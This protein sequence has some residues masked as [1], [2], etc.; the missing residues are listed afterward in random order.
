LDK[1][2]KNFTNILYIVIVIVII[3]LHKVVYV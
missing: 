3:L 1:D 2:I